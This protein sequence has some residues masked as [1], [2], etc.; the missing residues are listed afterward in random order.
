M[1]R[2]TQQ[3]FQTGGETVSAAG[4]CHPHIRTLEAVL[5]LALERVKVQNAFPACLVRDFVTASAPSSAA[6][7]V[8]EKVGLDEHDEAAEAV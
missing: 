1:R 4:G 3:D 7:L 6:I 2:L 8:L 5:E